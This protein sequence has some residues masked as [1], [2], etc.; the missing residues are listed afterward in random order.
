MRRA[1]RSRAAAFASTNPKQ[2]LAELD[3]LAIFSHHFSN[4]TA[5]FGFDFVHHF[6]RLDNANYRVLSDSVSNVDKRRAVRRSSL[7]ERPH[8]GRNDL[9]QWRA[10]GRFSHGSRTF[11]SS[12]R[13]FRRTDNR[14]RR[15]H[16]RLIG[17]AF[18]KLETK[19]V[20]F[21]LKNRKIVL[22][23]QIDE[24]FDFFD[25]FGV[26]GAL[27]GR[28]LSRLGKAV[29]VARSSAGME[30]WSIGAMGFDSASVHHSIA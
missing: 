6:H 11:R 30:Y 23:H 28:G 14:Q 5:R 4:D 2:H 22:L 18:L 1:R 17:C 16:G 13:R 10:C 24:G 20:L 27:R 26:Q 8:H 25:V 9:F 15:S 12:R 21:D 7:V 19:T 29:L 3:W